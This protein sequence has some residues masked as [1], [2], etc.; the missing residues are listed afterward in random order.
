MSEQATAHDTGNTIVFCTIPNLL[1]HKNILHFHHDDVYVDHV[2]HMCMVPKENKSRTFIVTEA[3]EL[4]TMHLKQE[5]AY[6]LKF[7]Q[8]IYGF[9]RVKKSFNK[10]KQHVK[11]DTIHD[12]VYKGIFVVQFEKT[13]MHVFKI[14]VDD[15]ED[16]LY[17]EDF[18]IHNDNVRVVE[19]EKTR[20]MTTAAEYY[21]RVT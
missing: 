20:H 19:Q 10:I 18:D 12:A 6:D 8:G 2:G 14:T 13:I 7:P 4:H 11:I 15:K 3:A 17:I 21:K 1:A 9:L 5:H 16:Q